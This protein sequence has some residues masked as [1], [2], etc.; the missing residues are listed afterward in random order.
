MAK[1]TQQI[2]KGWKMMN[3]N[4]FIELSYGSNLP[5]SKREPGSVPVYGSNGITDYHNKPLVKGPGLII[6]RKGS[7]GLVH[8]SKIN[9]WPIDTTYYVTESE[10]KNFKWI[11][12]KLQTLGLE[13]M[14]TASG[15]PGLNRNEVYSLKIAIPP[16]S[17]QVKIAAI[18]SKVDE[19][20]EKVERIIEQTEKLKKGLMQKL[21]TKG[22]GHTKFKKT[23]L[24]EIP[25]EWEMV[26]LSEA[27]NVIDSLHQTPE[28]SEHGYAMVRVA[29]IKPGFLILD[30]TQ[31]V[32]EDV[33]EEFTAKYRPQRNDIVLSRVGSYG[34]ISY[35]GTDEPFCMGQNTVVLKP[36]INSLYLFYYLNHE[37]VQSQIENEVSG[38]GYKS[39]SLKSI[40]E[41]NIA[42]PK[43]IE[44]EY[45]AKVLSSLDAKITN[46]IEGKTH[47]IKLKKGLMNDLLSGKIRIKI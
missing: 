41:L 25:E 45:I 42:L 8:W 35:V 28:F 46:N 15:I 39:L 36:N 2:P 5:K 29:D 1:I 10:N 16:L 11:Y 31:K 3:F 13:K 30:K 21:L 43:N 14:N 7:I 19:E 4:E 47:L 9:F 23:E 12:Y 44:Q 26:N 27:A 34:V 20:I 38:S 18:L 40:R 32:T 6:G 17:E 33:F 24:G 22:V 37:Q